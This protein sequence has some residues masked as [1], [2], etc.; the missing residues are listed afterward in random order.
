MVVCRLAHTL[1]GQRLRLIIIN[2]IRFWVH[3]QV[4]CSL[5]RRQAWENITKNANRSAIQCVSR[6]YM[7]RHWNIYPNKVLVAYKSVKLVS[8]P[9]T[10]YASSLGT[11]GKNRFRNQ[12]STEI[13]NNST[14]DIENISL[15]G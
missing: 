8:E 10:N 15:I 7:L 2:S 4:F 6:I 11:K 12:L 1:S 3:L 13:A 5:I 14:Q 9:D